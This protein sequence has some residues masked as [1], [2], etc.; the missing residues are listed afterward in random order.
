[1]GAMRLGP[2]RYHNFR[3]LWTSWT[4]A[5]TASWIHQVVTNWFIFELTDSPLMLGLNGIFTSVPFLITSLYGGALADRMDRRKILVISQVIS[6]FLA[7]IPGILTGLDVIRVWHL[8]TLGFL[9][10][11]I[12][13]FDGPARQALIPTVVPR[14]ELMRAVA[15]TTAVRRSMALVGPMIA[16]LGISLLG[17]T[18]TYFIYAALH[19]MVLITLY[20]M[21]MPSMEATIETKSMT[22]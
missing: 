4:L 20:L 5:A 7:I 11:I 16:G 13:G 14:G 15:L 19:G 6:T 9:N 10:A 22:R 18:W 21:R 17:V 1:M 3:L 12:T 8:Y 2:L